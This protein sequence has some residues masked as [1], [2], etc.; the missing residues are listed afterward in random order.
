MKR[1]AA[2]AAVAATIAGVSVLA[3][4]PGRK[5]LSSYDPQVKALLAKM[6]LDEKIGQ[7]TQAEQH[8]IAQGDV[9]RYFL[10]S[11]LSGGDSDPKTNSLLDWTDMYD[12]YQ[13]R[14]LRTRLRIPILYGVDAVHGHNNVQGT[15][16]FPHNIGLGATRDPDL[17][18]RIGRATAEELAATGIPWDFAPVVA[19]PRDIRW[20]RAYEAYG[21]DTALVTELG[22]AYLRGL[23]GDGLGRPFSVLATPK[24]YIGDGGTSLGSASASGSHVRR[25]ADHGG[26]HRYQQSRVRAQKAGAGCR[27][28]DRTT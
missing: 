26:A 18:E 1:S 5:P 3:A 7:M 8:Q 17:V 16:V 28:C 19:V 27:H 9:E 24:H 22:T 13:A 15:V 11:V 23:Q 25:P 4:P 10:G 20:G 6:T 2:V 12:R 21:E 14:A